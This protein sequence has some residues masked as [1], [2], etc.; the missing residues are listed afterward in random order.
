M[1]D[2]ELIRCIEEITDMCEEGVITA[3]EAIV[4]IMMALFDAG[5]VTP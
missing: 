1:T 4:K 3:E 5:R 2:Q